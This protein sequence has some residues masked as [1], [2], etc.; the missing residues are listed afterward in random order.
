GDVAPFAKNA[1]RSI[2]IVMVTSADPVKGGLVASLARPGANVTGLTLL[3]ADLAAKRIQL[4]KE[5][6]PAISRMGVIWN[7]DHADDEMQETQAAARTLGIQ[8][9]SLPVQRAGDFE[10]ALPAAVKGR[11]E[12]TSPSRHR[13]LGAR[14]R[15]SSDQGLGVSPRDIAAA[16][17]RKRTRSGT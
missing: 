10:S 7:P 11:V 17:R 13:C 5:A 8:V 4:L 6:I 3:S 9:Q 16:R 1:T 14:T 2:P 15:S 12:S